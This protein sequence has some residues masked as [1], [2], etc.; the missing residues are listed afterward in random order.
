[1]A[2]YKQQRVNEAVRGMVS[3]W[4][5]LTSAYRKAL[6]GLAAE[7]IALRQERTALALQ[8]TDLQAQMK[9]AVEA[10]VKQ[11]LAGA[12]GQVVDEV[13]A[14]TDAL[15]H[16]VGIMTHSVADAE[17]A[18]DGSSSGRAATVA[19]G[20]GDSGDFRRGRLAGQHRRAMVG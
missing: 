11:S 3:A 1:M 19:G 9:A 17:F 13:K 15:D 2:A 18:L 10:A 14:K 7:R 8:V 16:N 4:A 6:D 5:Q 12:A 20:G